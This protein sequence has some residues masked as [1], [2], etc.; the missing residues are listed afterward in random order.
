MKRSM[1]AGIASSLLLTACKNEI[2][3]APAEPAPVNVPSPAVPDVAPVNPEVPKQGSDTLVKV[4]GKI[5]NVDN[6]SG[7]N[8]TSFRR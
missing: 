6:K 3:V 1:V 5:M 4:D 7:G 8:K 2:P